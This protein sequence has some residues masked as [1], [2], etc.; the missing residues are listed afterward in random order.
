[1]A[2]ALVALCNMA[3]IASTV[4]E[5]GV[6]YELLV[7]GESVSIQAVDR[8][9]IQ[10][11]RDLGDRMAFE[12]DADLGE[13]V[14]V[15]VTFRNRPVDDAISVLCKQVGYL[16]ARNPVDQ[17]IHRLVLTSK[18]GKVNRAAARPADPP[19]WRPSQPPPMDPPDVDPAQ[20]ASDATDDAHAGEPKRANRQES[21]TKKDD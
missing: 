4:D 10:I 14:R 17:R 5:T 15:T 16:I 21:Q 11:L 13:D 18:K 9:L 19:G 20:A 6:D 12:V 2:L 7:E 1:M 3:S 8:P